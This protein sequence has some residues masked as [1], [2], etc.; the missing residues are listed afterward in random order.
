MNFLNAIIIHE[1]IFKAAE[2]FTKYLE[3]IDILNCHFLSNLTSLLAEVVSPFNF[4]QE[5]CIS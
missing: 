4:V 3:R 5:F 2:V 1:K